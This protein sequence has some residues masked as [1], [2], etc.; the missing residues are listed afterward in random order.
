MSSTTGHTSNDPANLRLLD[1][2]T[3]FVTGGAN[4]IGQA[5]VERFVREGAF[6]AF[7]DVDKEQ[8]NR[9]ADRLIREHQHDR[10]ADPRRCRFVHCDVTDET[11]VA[12]A[13]SSLY[14]SAN[15]T[16][17]KD[18]HRPLDILV[19]N[20][21]AFVFGKVHECA[22]D[23]WNKV[24]N[25]NVKGYIWTIKN[26]MQYLA[27]GENK[28]PVVINIGSVSSFIAQP[29]FVPYNASKGAIVELTRCLSQQYPNIAFFLAC[30]G[31]IDTPA[32]ARHA[33]HEGK[34]K[35]QVAQELS[36]LHMIPRMGRPEEVANVVVFLASQQSAV[37]R[38]HAF[39]VDGGWTAR[40]YASMR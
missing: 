7:C 14:A 5:I 16:V 30:P 12:R 1:G 29:A 31:G 18:C 40:K 33:K 37:R 35:E 3:A 24:L 38:G 28:K 32:T 20:A 19:N 2:K 10:S 26:A 8:G 25:V 6:V 22:E 11:S 9:L 36:H 13:F 23:D 4:G 15:D 39:M 17:S 34:T 21:A 27:H